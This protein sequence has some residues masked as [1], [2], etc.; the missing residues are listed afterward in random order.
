MAN[1]VIFNWPA[2]TT[3]A[4]SQTQ[5]LGEAGDL[6]I[7]GSLASGGTVAFQGFAR[8]ASLTSANDLSAVSFI[9]SGT[10]NGLSIED[11]INGPNANTVES[12]LIFDT[13]TNVSINSSV[14]DVSVGTGTTGRTGWFRHNHQSICPVFVIQV[15][16]TDTINYSFATS[17]SAVD[18]QPESSIPLFYPMS[19]MVGA[20]SSMLASYMVPSRHSA[21]TINSS[22]DTGSLQ[23]IFLQQGNI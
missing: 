7:N 9:I 17:L 2:P 4:I 21:I 18:F 1:P 6:M 10:I 14:T 19:G 15:T 16:V 11:T 12:D 23:A 22:N 8:A 5:S 13:I 20:T 3:Q